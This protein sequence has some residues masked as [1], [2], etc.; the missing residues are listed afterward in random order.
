MSEP[1]AKHPIKTQRDF[2]LWR[3]Y[4]MEITQEECA[5]LLGYKS[6][7]SIAKLESGE[8]KITPRITLAVESI[9]TNQKN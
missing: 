2:K 9:N 3:A 8:Q 5:K 6:R 4:D 7:H 1:L